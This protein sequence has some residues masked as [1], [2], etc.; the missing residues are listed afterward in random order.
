MQSRLPSGSS[1]HAPSPFLRAAFSNIGRDSWAL[2]E[3]QDEIADRG[4][5]LAFPTPAV[6]DIEV[7]RVGLKAMAFQVRPKQA[8]QIVRRRRLTESA[9][10]IAAALNCE[11]RGTANAAGIDVPPAVR[12][13]R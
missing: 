7:A 3:S 11:Q 2:L 12:N 5:N 4:I 6:E 8:A 10:I 9:N 1:P 13:F